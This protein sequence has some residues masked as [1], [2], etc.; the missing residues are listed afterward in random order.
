MQ[1]KRIKIDFSARYYQLGQLSEE[2]QQL[3]F[4]LHGHGHLAQYFIRK[5]AALDNDNNVIIAPEG[6]N[7]YYL[8][9]FTGK[10]GATWMTKEDRLT[11]I[12]NYV[13]FLNEVYW[14]VLEGVD[15]QNLKI[16]LLGFSQGAATVSRWALDDKVNF[17]RLILWAGIFPPDID[18]DFGRQ[19]LAGVE[20]LSVVGDEDEYLNENVVKEQI[21]LE[22]K[23]GIESRKIN[24][25]GRHEINEEVLLSLA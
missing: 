15:F 10:V 11:D 17:D 5:F 21:A 1:E 6:L 18:F 25:S 22:Q 16:T 20:V 7:R 4:V 8:E 3:W 23:L 9:G 14:N 19:K 13:N 12:G 2:T 24:F